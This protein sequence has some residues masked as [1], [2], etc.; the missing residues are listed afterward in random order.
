M[1]DLICNCLVDQ[2]SQF[3]LIVKIIGW[4]KLLKINHHHVFLGIYPIG[5][6]IRTS[7]AILPGRSWCSSFTDVLTDGEAQSESFT[8]PEIYLSGVAHSHELYCFPGKDTFSVGHT[9]VEE[10]MKKLCIVRGRRQQAG[11]ARKTPARTFYVSA[12]TDRGPRIRG[13]L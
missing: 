3:S 10:H 6:A 9:S 13:T 1:M 11:A 5:G 12:L 7:P 2:C 8:C 4:D